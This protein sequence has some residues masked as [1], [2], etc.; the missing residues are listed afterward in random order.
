MFTC[1]CVSSGK[2]ASGGH[3]RRYEAR[4][5][6]ERTLLRFQTPQTLPPPPSSTSPTAHVRPESPP[7]ASVAKQ[8]TTRPTNQ[9]TNL[10]A[11][12]SGQ[13]T[14]GKWLTLTTGQQ[15]QLTCGHRGRGGRAQRLHANAV[16]HRTPASSSVQHLASAHAPQKGRGHLRV[17]PRVFVHRPR[18]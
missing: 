15:V 8:R 6:D 1:G 12:P 11:Q 3:Q 4:R 18:S 10:L 7:G 9:L 5:D 17:G 14:R 2:V 13:H 16:L